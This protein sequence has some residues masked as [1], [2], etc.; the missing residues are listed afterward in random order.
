M[1]WIQVL[2]KACAMFS[3]KPKRQI[4]TN[5]TSMRW[6]MSFVSNQLT[7]K[8]KSLHIF[9]PKMN[10]T[11][12]LRSPKPEAC[13]ILRSGVSDYSDDSNVKKVHE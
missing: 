5:K 13:S 11:E 6:K 12:N 8:V 10:V 3:V 9:Q 4:M 7:I 2:S 1:I